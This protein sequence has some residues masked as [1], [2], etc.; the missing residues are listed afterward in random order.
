[1]NAIPLAAPLPLADV[2]GATWRVG[3]RTNAIAW[4]GAA[5]TAWFGL[6]DGSLAMARSVWEGR[7]SVRPREGGGAELVPANDAPP[8]VARIAVHRGAC[9]ALAADPESGLL[10][11]GTDGEFA[12]VAADGT[13]DTLA[14]FDA[15]PAA[16][17][18]A[19]RGGWR[20][21]AAGSVLVRLGAGARTLD[22]PGT[23]TALAMAPNGSRVAIGYAGGITLWA[24][25]DT[26][27][28]LEGGGT[29]TSL[30][31]SKE[32][33]SLASATEAG[34]V[35]LWEIAGGTKQPIGERHPGRTLGFLADGRL[36]VSTGGSL[37]C[38]D[39][40]DGS[41]EPCGTASRDAVQRLAC[42]P[43]RALLAAG[44][45]NGAIVICRPGN[46]EIVFV[47]GPGEGPIEALDWSPA[48]DTLAYAAPGS[49]GLVSLPGLLFREGAAP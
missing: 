24:G 39:P 29:P 34:D 26:P 3:A 10:S 6:D 33:R 8:P 28:V 7:P 1:M 38:H 31:W 13:I 22:L 47:R 49:I 36:I 25:G 30:V 46:P 4:D 42:H 35:L 48:G 16:P 15:V 18:A 17:L 40:R 5:G 9:L 32:S 41:S 11:G 12:R 21:C 43:R 2:L 20:V 19:G 44:Y 14:R 27:R 45:M 23:I 37:A